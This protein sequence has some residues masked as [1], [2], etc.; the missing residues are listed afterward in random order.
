MRLKKYINQSGF[1]LIELMIVVA[2]IGILAAIATPQFTMYQRRSYNAA[3]TS[4]LVNFQKAE[5]T[6]YNDYGGFGS[7]DSAAH[8]G[9]DMAGVALDGPGNATTGIAG[10]GHYI[11]VAL[12]NGVR[13]YCN[14]AGGGQTFSVS[15]KHKAGNRAYASEAEQTATF[16]GQD[17]GPGGLTAPAQPW[18]ALTV[19]CTPG[20][21][22]VSGVTAI[23]MAVWTA[24]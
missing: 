15:A 8:P 23:G 11:P 1:T 6:F 9:W 14:T 5:T 22:I 24:M 18:A 21:D 20:T 19:N 12:S 4:D 16:F 10:D 3:A 7:S 17:D 2:I 13:L